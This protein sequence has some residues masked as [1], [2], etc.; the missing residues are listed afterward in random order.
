VICED[1][2]NITELAARHVLLGCDAVDLQAATYRSWKHRLFLTARAVRALACHSPGAARAQAKV[3]ML[4]ST[5][6]GKNKLALQ[7]VRGQHD[8]RRQGTIGAAFLSK[9]IDTEEGTVKLEIWDAAGQ[10]RY[11][12]LA[13][14]FYRCAT[15][16]VVVFQLGTRMN[17]G[18][19]KAG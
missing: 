12:S 13:P 15:A 16:A 5:Q 17:F 11:R 8:E 9:E 2:L 3:V 7:F 19:P 10:E 14:M 1:G 18:K 4:G 6:S